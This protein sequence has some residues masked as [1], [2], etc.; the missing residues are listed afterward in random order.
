MALYFRGQTAIVV[1][2]SKLIFHVP[3]PGCGV[4]RAVLLAL[5]GQVIEAL[6]FNPNVI[7]AL[8]FIFLYPILIL[9]DG[10]TQK[11]HLF[12]IYY[13]LDAA[14][15]RP[16][17]FVPFGVFEIIIWIHNIVCHI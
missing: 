12:T 11:T 2:P 7:F 15:K 9:Y 4:T 10:L 1:C 3:C 13:S 6:C 14:L 17:F 5:H 16:M 8:G